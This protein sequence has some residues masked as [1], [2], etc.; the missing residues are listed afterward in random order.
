MSTIYETKHLSIKCQRTRRNHELAPF[1][2]HRRNRNMSFAPPKTAPN[3]SVRQ[4]YWHYFAFINGLQE[5]INADIDII[6]RTW[7]SA[8]GWQAVS[9]QSTKSTITITKPEDGSLYR[10]CYELTVQRLLMSFE[11]N[12][13]ISQCLMATR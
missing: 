9:H 4:L 13:V 10:L 7:S 11:L 6:I 3:C 5:W 8:A 1:I 12:P 2:V